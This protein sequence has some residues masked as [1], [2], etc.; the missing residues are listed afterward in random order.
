ML[1]R[2]N[3]LSSNLFFLFPHTSTETVSPLH[4]NRFERRQLTSNKSY[5]RIIRSEK[6]EPFDEICFKRTKSPIAV[7]GAAPARSLL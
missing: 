3:S 2:E 7:S 4:V 6:N 5:Y 1:S